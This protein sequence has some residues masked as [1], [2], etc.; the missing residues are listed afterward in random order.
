MR[1][2]LP[3]ADEIGESQLFEQRR[4][5][6]GGAPD[7]VEAIDE[8]VRDDDEAEAHRREDRLG[9]G[10]DVN[11]RPSTSSPCRHCSGRVA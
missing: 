5:Q 10:A 11:D 9:K 1:R 8:I 4:M 7:R 3:L 2:I 6:I